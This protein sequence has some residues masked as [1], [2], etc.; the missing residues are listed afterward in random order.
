MLE[1]AGFIVIIM[2]NFNV[3]FLPY[4][5]NISDNKNCPA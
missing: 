1:N 4:V 3:H 5:Q 2:Q